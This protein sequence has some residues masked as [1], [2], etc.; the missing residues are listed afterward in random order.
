MS[1][2][3]GQ[4]FRP[5]YDN[6]HIM[7]RPTIL[8]SMEPG[9]TPGI[10]CYQFL[11]RPVA[12]CKAHFHP[13]PQ[14]HTF[15]FPS[16]RAQ[17]LFTYTCSCALTKPP[18]CRGCRQYGPQSPVPQQEEFYAAPHRLYLAALGAPPY[19]HQQRLADSPWPDVLEIP[20]GLGKT[21]AIVMAWLYKRCHL[22]AQTPRRLVWCLPMHILVEQTARLVRQWIERL[23][24]KGLLFHA[25]SVHVLMGGDVSRD[26]DTRPEDEAIHVGTQDQLLSQA[27]N[28]GYAMSRFRWP[29]DFALRIMARS[30]SLTRFSSWAQGCPHPPSWT[31]LLHKDR[32]RKYMRAL[33][34]PGITPGIHRRPDARSDPPY[35]LQWS[36][37][38]LP[39]Y[40]THMGS[41]TAG[42]KKLQ[43]NPGYRPMSSTRSPTPC[44]NGARDHSP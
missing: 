44:F 30:G 10:H 13:F 27:L 16:G 41:R 11:P 42:T 12:V 24:D 5:G 33:M 28:R 17:I 23:L 7:C 31:T 21:A 22:D 43:W 39:G 14:K 36:L 29:L 3:W 8:T 37:G 2:Q 26:W 34:E 1:C 4:G 35:R 38:L 18:G 25:P 9:I 6:R 32:C 20:T 15:P 40:T 19:P